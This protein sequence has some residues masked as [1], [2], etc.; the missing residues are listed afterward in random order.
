MTGE[1]DGAKLK[2]HSSESGH[3]ALKPAQFDANCLNQE[4]KG[5]E[6]CLPRLECRMLIRRDGAQRAA[7]QLLSLGKREYTCPL[8]THTQLFM[9]WKER[10]I[11]LQGSS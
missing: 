6:G 8:C 2:F 11:A 5:E 10:C 4:I 3:F 1:G 7:M 9:D